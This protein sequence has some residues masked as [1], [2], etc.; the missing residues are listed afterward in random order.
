MKGLAPSHG[1]ILG[2]LILAGQL[3]MKELARATNRDKSTVT[4]LVNKLVSLG[5]VERKTDAGDGRVTLVQLSAKGRSIE[6]KIRDI[7][8]KL[9]SLAY[10]NISKKEREVLIDLLT[11]IENN[12]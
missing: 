5:Y 2:A 11:R 10:R 3:S 4:A 6:P 7:G 8:R 1:D 12:L 9:R